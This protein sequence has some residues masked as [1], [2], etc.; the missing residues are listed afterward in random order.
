MWE[1]GADDDTRAAM[2]A[3]GESRRREGKKKRGGGADGAAEAAAGRDTK[4]KR[5][6]KKVPKKKA[7]REEEGAPISGAV[8]ADGCKEGVGE[9]ERAEKV[10]REG[11]GVG[12]FRARET[13]EKLKAP[14][15][16]SKP[17]KRITMRHAV[18]LALRRAGDGGMS[19]EEIVNLVMRDRRLVIKSKSPRG[20]ITAVLWNRSKSKGLFV[21]AGPSRHKLAPG[22]HIPDADCGVADEDAY[23]PLA[24]PPAAAANEPRDVCAMLSVIGERRVRRSQLTFTPVP[25]V[26]ESSRWCGLAQSGRGDVVK[27]QAS[28][29]EE[30]VRLGGSSESPRQ[31]PASVV[32]FSRT[33]EVLGRREDAGSSGP[34]WRSTWPAQSRTPTRPRARTSHHSRVSVSGL[35]R[36]R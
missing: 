21:S 29:A 19:T 28:K 1:G 33:E 13:A 11:G 9:P 5:T 4:R 8:E 15:K 18:A 14:G 16:K 32:L 22:V 12:T 20:S 2:N 17:K 30:P 36:P 6:T 23:D 10:G 3:L 24:S 25:R 31:P 7:E 27:A 26:D 34:G 35:R